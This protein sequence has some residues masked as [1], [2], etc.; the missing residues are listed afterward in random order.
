MSPTATIAH[1]TERMAH[2][3]AGIE[4]RYARA[5]VWLRAR[6]SYLAAGNVMTNDPR[7]RARSVELAGAA[8]CRAMAWSCL[9]EGEPAQAVVW[10]REATRQQLAIKAAL[11]REAAR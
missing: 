2:A 11:R 10:R 5:Q 8:A 7:G 6:D 9:A 3:R 4:R 1:L